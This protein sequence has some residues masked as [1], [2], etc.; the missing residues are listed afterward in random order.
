MEIGEYVRA[1]RRRLWIV[2]G[3]PVLVLI[4]TGVV[5]L[6]RPREYRVTATVVVPATQVV[7]SLVTVVDQSVADFEGAIRSEAVFE[8]VA[9]VTGVS[10]R[11]VAA[12]LS[13]RRLGTSSVVEVTYQ[14]TE[15]ETASAVAGSA[16]KQALELVQQ[17]VFGPLKEQRTVAEQQYEAAMTAV[18]G[19]LSETGLVNPSQVFKIQ[20]SRLVALRDALGH[21]ISQGQGAEARRLRE[22][23][24]QK[25][26]EVTQQVVTYQRLTDQRQRA[27]SALQAADNQYFQARGSLLSAQEGETI[28]VSE[29]EPLPRLG[30]TAVRQLV[31]AG[32]IACALAIGLVV[33]LELLS[34][35]PRKLG[36]PAPEGP[37]GP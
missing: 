16:S 2:V 29:P 26:A 36:T 34:V 11:A 35:P 22:Q 33:L 19:F 27:L 31:A 3:V 8:R 30:S 23:I 18:E 7:G 37:G 5:L 9:D 13:T 14:T 17:S 32:V 21:A 1:I 4:A 10:K 15:S 6:V 24:D 28:T 12:G 25:E 20:A